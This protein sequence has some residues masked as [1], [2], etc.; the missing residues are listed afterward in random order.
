MA[1]PSKAARPSVLSSPCTN[2]TARSGACRIYSIH[3]YITKT[4][5]SEQTREI[6]CSK[7]TESNNYEFQSC[8]CMKAQRLVSLLSASIVHKLQPFACELASLRRQPALQRGKQPA[9]IAEAFVVRERQR[10]HEAE[11]EG[12]VRRDNGLVDRGLDVLDGL[13]GQMKKGCV[14]AGA[15]SV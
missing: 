6:G 7:K 12:L 10:A 15:A 5:E 1:G 2:K 9:I 4:F 14:N 8:V 11:D 13:Q 3:K